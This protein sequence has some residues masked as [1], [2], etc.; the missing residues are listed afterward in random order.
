MPGKVA[1][2]LYILLTSIFYYTLF[3]LACGDETYSGLIFH[4][5]MCIVWCLMCAFHVYLIDYDR[6]NTLNRDIVMLISN[7][8]LFII[9]GA[10]MCLNSML[11][12]NLAGMMIVLAFS[13]K[14]LLKD[15]EEVFGIL[16]LLDTKHLKDN[17]KPDEQE[18]NKEDDK[19]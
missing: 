2:P 11:E 16:Y 17:K 10:A 4:M 8:E 14:I 15:R 5:V 18:E 7:V 12:F 3:Y 1:S 19:K 9:I 6:I 13:I